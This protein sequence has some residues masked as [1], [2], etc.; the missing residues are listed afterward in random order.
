M[1]R[2]V[3]FLTIVLC[4]CL[5]LAC[6]SDPTSSRPIANPAPMSRTIQNPDGPGAF[7]IRFQDIVAFAF[8]SDD[9]GMTVV[10]GISPEE[11]PLLCSGS[12]EITF[13][14]LS[15]QVLLRPDGTTHEVGRA[16]KVEVAIFQ[17]V[18]N[19]CAPPLGLGEGG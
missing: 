17:G 16:R 8:V 12:G 19:F 13:D 18:F 9:L 1:F 6:S 7:V 14:P 5:G 2:S 4:S 3:T 15:T 10:T 11:L